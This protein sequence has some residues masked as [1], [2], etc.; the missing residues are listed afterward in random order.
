MNAMASRNV[1]N[2]Y[3]L[4]ISPRSW[5]HPGRSSSAAR[6]SSSESP[7][8]AE[9]LPPGDGLDLVHGALQLL[10]HGPAEPAPHGGE[11]GPV[12]ADLVLGRPGGEPFPHVRPLGAEVPE[13]GPGVVQ[14]VGD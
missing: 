1:G 11:H 7:G 6:I 3:C 14:L 9:S 13:D 4:K 2:L 12:V 10:D 5:R 8:M